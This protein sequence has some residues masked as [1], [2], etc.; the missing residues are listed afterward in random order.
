MTVAMMVECPW[1]GAKPHRRCRRKGDNHE[2]VGT[3]HESR[4][5]AARL[6]DAEMRRTAGKGEQR[7]KQHSQ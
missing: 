4:L 1:C 2:M 6:F 3:F 5:R 7:A